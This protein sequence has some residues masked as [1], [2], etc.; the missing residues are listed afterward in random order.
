M[1]IEI[2]TPKNPIK[3]RRINTN[4]TPKYGN[5]SSAEAATGTKRFKRAGTTVANL[6]FNKEANYYD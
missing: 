6:Y 1:I 3:K 5:K 2:L 4:E